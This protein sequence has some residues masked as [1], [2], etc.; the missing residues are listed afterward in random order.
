M[1]VRHPPIEQVVTDAARR[2]ARFYVL[3]GQHRLSTMVELA[4]ERPN[5]PIWFELSIKV[6]ADKLAANAALLHMQR[7][8]TA[9]CAHTRSHR[10]TCPRT[11]AHTRTGARARAARTPCSHLW[12]TFTPPTPTCSPKCFFSEDDEAD[13]ASRTLDLARLR[14][15]R[16]FV[17]SGA[18][19]S[20]A[21]PARPTI[22]PMLDDGLFFDL[23]R[24]TRLLL[25]VMRQRTLNTGEPLLPTARPQHLFEALKTINDAIREEGPP[26]KVAA[27]TFE[28]CGQKLSGCFLGLYRRDETG[29]QTMDMLRRRTLV[30]PEATCALDHE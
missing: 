9:K 17:A 13:V 23:L 14:W 6:V 1:A 30:P 28:R 25:E 21:P 26:G 15:P 4:R 18:A 27:R 8:Y 29:L 10:R 5:V 19:S 3:D 7:C 11:D 22:R 20:F 12:L 24:D 2:F 16:A